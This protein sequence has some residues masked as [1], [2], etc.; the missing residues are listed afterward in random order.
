[1]KKLFFLVSV[2]IS[3]VSIAQNP[4]ATIYLNSGEEQIAY[5]GSNT[6][7]PEREIRKKGRSATNSN[8][9]FIT[10]DGDNFIYFTKAGDIERMDID[11]IKKVV[12]DTKTYNNLQVTVVANQYQTKFAEVSIGADKVT[13]KPMK[14]KKK[15][16]RMLQL[17]AENDNYILANLFSSGINHFYIFDKEGNLI[18]KQVGH[19]TTKKKCE[20]ALVLVKQYFGDCT[21][22][23]SRMEEN[24]QNTFGK[25]MQKQHLLLMTVGEDN[26]G[27]NYITGV[28]C[29]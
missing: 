26:K 24:M 20:K 4:Y 23:I 13:F 11:E 16:V 14:I 29:N 28:E 10:L 27:S 7:E 17:I 25:G 19:S 8:L 9:G 18:E 6:E 5:D 15:M 22:L 3:G 21:E 1:M 12:V 2:L